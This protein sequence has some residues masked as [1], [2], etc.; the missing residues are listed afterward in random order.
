[1]KNLVVDKDN[2]KKNFNMNKGLIVAEP[3]YILLAAKNHP[4][5]HEIVRKLTLK[6][7]LMK[8]PLQEL[9][10]KEK[11]LQGYLKKFNKKQLDIIKNPEKYT[12]IASKKAESVCKFWKKELKI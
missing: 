12:G 5:A 9:I 2:I 6:S 3:L 10:K 11:S 4:D 8:K 1:M 7:Q